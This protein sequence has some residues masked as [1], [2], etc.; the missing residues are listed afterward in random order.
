VVYPISSQILEYQ[1]HNQ[2]WF[3]CEIIIPIYLIPYYRSLIS[4]HISN[5]YDN[6]KCPTAVSSVD[7]SCTTKRSLSLLLTRGR[8]GRERMVAWYSAAYAISSYHYKSCE[9]EHRSWRGVLDSTLCD[10]VCQFF[11]GFLY[12]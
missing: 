3:Q 8:H 6:W 12:Q 9:F 10:K 4:K 2:H 1:F 7:K 11:S 5:A